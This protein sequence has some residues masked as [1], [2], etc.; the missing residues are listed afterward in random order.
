MAEDNCFITLTYSPEHLPSAGSLVHRDFQL[1]MK[2]LRKRFAPRSI[3]YFMCGEYGE[4][5]ARPHF[6]ACLFNI[7]FNLDKQYFK[8]SSA[9]NSQ[10]ALPIYLYTSPTLTALWPLGHSSVGELTLQSAGYTARYCL[11]KITGQAAA[12]HY[13]S[14][15]PEYCAMSRRDGI[16]A[17]W[18]ARYAASDVLPRDYVVTSKGHTVPLPP[19]Y[20]RLSKRRGIDVSQVKADRELKAMPYRPDNIPSRLRD[21]EIVQL[22]AVS[23]L[24]RTL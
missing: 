13:G 18:F 8:T 11:K 9:A 23:Y 15:K 6:H 7:N 5:F 22:A 17:T 2:R 14:R 19:Y 24:K 4:D 3:R 10:S 20:D 16:G 1:F 21:K 12:D